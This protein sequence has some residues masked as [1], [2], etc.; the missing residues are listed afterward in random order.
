[1]NDKRSAL[2]SLSATEKAIVLDQLLADR[3]ELREPAEA[4]AV[5][6]MKGA[7]RSAVADEVESALQ[8]LDIDELNTR[9][10]HR[11]GRGYVHPAEAADEILDEALEPFLD[12]LQRRASLGM[13]S[14][15]GELAAGILLGLYN[16]RDGNSETLLEYAPDFAVE[17]ASA[18]VSDCAKLGI[19]LPAAE[20]LDLLP[21]W[22]DLLT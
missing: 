22:S 15:A 7:D 18:V 4:C 20:L 11:P 1:M 9:A 16:C 17:R 3:P 5:Q 6:L 12:D 10:G 21:A 19:E 2:D 14:A 13:G 8:Y